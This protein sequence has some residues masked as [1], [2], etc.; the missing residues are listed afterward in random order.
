MALD[1]EEALRVALAAV[2]ASAPLVRAAHRRGGAVYVKDDDSVVTDTDRAVERTL[3]GFIEAAFPSHDV[4]GE[5]DGGQLSGSEW[6]WMI[7]PI[8]GTVSFV[9]GL[10][11]AATLVALCREGRPVLSV[12]DF[13]LQG[14]AW[15]LAG[16]GAWEGRERL[17]VCEGFHPQRSV[18]CHGDLYTFQMAGYERAYRELERR[19]PHFRSY[20][21]AFGH[22]LVAQ[23]AAAAVVDA[24]M[25]RWDVA[26]VRLL[27]EEAGG[28]TVCLPDRHDEKRSVLISGAAAAVDWLSEHVL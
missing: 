27:V 21:D 28:K 18:V 8:D 25:E 16:K 14:R 24:A 20:T 2:D 6:C 12:V 3:R 4:L 7:D 10:P 15:A 11:F 17:R 9:N 26:A 5:E 23:G 22:Y 19:C 1:L 13:P